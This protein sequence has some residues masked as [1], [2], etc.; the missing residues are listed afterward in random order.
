VGRVKAVP[1]SALQWRRERVGG[2]EV[3]MIFSLKS[4]KLFAI[5]EPPL[6]DVWESITAGRS[7]PED[8]ENMKFVRSLET[9]SLV[10]MKVE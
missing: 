8:D 2:E 1:V 9:Q 5:F 10:K 4:Q 7:I 6:M 3:L